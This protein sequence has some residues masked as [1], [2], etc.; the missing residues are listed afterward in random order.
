MS[1]V[2]RF[3]VV[4]SFSYIVL[5]ISWKILSKFDKAPNETPEE[6]SAREAHEDERWYR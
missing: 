5:S 4:F 2:D 6:R 1:A 3:M